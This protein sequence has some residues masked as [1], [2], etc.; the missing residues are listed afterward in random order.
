MKKII[1]ALAALMLMIT[2]CGAVLAEQD[3]LEV[4]D[5]CTF[6]L[7]GNKSL[8]NL[9]DRKFTTF[10]ESKSV[11]NP[12]LTVSSTEPVYGLYLCF[13]KKPESY[14]IQVKQADAWTTVYEG[15]EFIHAFYELDGV[16][17][18]RVYAEGSK[19]QTFGFNEI[20][21]FGE[22]RI[23]G[24][25]QRW[26]PTP[27]KSDVLF[28]V[29]H[30]EEELLY[31]GGAIPYYAVEQGRTVAVACMSVAK[32]TRR[33]ELLNGLWSLGYRNY[34]VIGM[35]KAAKSKGVASAYRTISAQN[36][37]KTLVSWLTDVLNRTR[38]EVMVGPDEKGEGGNGQRMMLADACRKAFAA[39]D[40]WQV[41]KLYLH[42]Y[43][44]AEDQ[45]IFDWNQPMEK[46]GGRNGMGLAYYAYLF[47][48]TQDDQEKSVYDQGIT[49]ACNTFGLAESM[50]GPDL[51]HEDLLENIP[52]EDLTA[53]AEAEEV[54]AWSLEEVPGLPELNEKGYL[55]SGEFIWSDD[56]RGYY[57]YISETAKLIIRRKFDGSL[58]LTW[59]ETEIWCDL[60]AG[61]RIRNVEYTPGKAVGKKSRVDAAKNAV[62][63]HLVFAC[64][65]D[66]YTYR[67][68]SK[69]GH[70][71][72]V[73]I[74][75]SQIY[76]DDRYDH[77]EK[78][79]FP[80]L[81]TLAFY[82]DGSVDVHASMEL[83][84][85]EYLDRSAYLVY[86]FGPYLIRS[87]ELSE[88][89]QDPTKSRAKNPRH[90]FGMI[91]P[92]HYVDIMCEGRLGSRSE[93]VTMPQ[94]A[95]LCQAAGLKE[96]CDLDGG[97][98]AVVVFMGKQLNKIG[99]YDG[100]TAARETCEVMGVGVSDQ[101]GTWKI[102]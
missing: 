54:S 72:G 40:S 86:S 45:V 33:G 47:H 24:W 31:L 9:T 51:I 42:L 87:G 70:P 67:V 52:L 14:E 2:V 69:N 27:E 77:V 101:V 96:A 85:Q 62:A 15:S 12:T 82:E 44:G 30:P 83:S 4:T 16:R 95:Q 6:S 37:E 46:F 20:Y 32:T 43:G 78:K 19:K 92:G 21:V 56:A 91:E 55:D 17:E 38:P 10:S 80:N 99:K 71:V 100:K 35:F 28:V 63:N 26:N 88:W 58:P 60:E 48:K 68:G 29:A 74:R 94:L 93:G 22:G 76:F 59:F 3:A 23:P 102:Q 75:N 57:V 11:K 5:K 49:Y 61:E 81:D 13:Q 90:A 97:Q 39:A 53:P 89:V 66:Y 79:F 50:V 36:G 7:S 41:Q 18:I 34:P 64:N 1:W 65:M 84:A 8:K 25:V 98:T 73:E